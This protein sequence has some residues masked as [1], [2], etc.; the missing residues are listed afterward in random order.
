MSQKYQ[1][2]TILLLLLVAWLVLD[3]RW[4]WLVKR[5]PPQEEGEHRIHWLS[6]ISTDGHYLNRQQRQ[7]L[8]D[9]ILQE[10]KRMEVWHQ[11]HLEQYHLKL[12]QLRSESQ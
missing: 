9:N 12:E 4:K 7:E 6:R 11:M 1:W 3:L 10:Q 2:I 5:Q 8:N